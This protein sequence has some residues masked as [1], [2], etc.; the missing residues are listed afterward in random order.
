MNRNLLKE[1]PMPGHD[2]HATATG[3]SVE[4][5]IDGTPNKVPAGEY[6][7]AAFKELVGVDAS[8]ELEQVVEGKLVPL[9][10]SDTIDLEKSGKRFVSHVRRGGS[11]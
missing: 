10:D 5:I 11:S 3:K 7:V 4:V 9:A 1:N 6:V 2:Q 8:K